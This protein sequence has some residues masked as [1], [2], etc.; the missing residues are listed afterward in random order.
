MPIDADFAAALYRENKSIT[1][2]AR[3]LG[4]NKSRTRAAIVAG[5]IEIVPRM[6]P[7]GESF[8]CSCNKA[9]PTLCA[10]IDC[11]IEDAG[12]MLAYMGA[13][14]TEKPTKAQWPDGTEH[15]VMHYHVTA[16]HNYEA[17]PLSI[18]KK[19]EH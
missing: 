4:A 3:I 17:G 8:C 9:I 15:T 1:K 7:R 19:R 14:S 16:C 5:G 6:L 18:W 2:T 10:F 12:A 13:T 11:E